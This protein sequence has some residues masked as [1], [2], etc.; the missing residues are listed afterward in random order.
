MEKVFI[1]TREASEFLG[2]KMNTMYQY[3]SKGI[4]PHY[5]RGGKVYFIKDELVN[6]VK[7]GKIEIPV[8]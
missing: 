5:K 1:N 3:T 2:I 6:W 8:R 4:L 7:Q